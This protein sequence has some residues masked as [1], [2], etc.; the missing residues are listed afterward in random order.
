MKKHTKNK[1][2]LQYSALKSHS[3]VPGCST[4]VQYSIWHLGLASSVWSRSV[5]DQR[6]ESRWEMVELRDQNNRRQRA[7]CSFTHSHPE[8]EIKILYYTL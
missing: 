7:S 5:T 8:L 3:T 4:V 1:E 6:K 2:I